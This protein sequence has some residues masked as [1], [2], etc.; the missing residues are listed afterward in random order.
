M[1]D[2][3]SANEQWFT[4]AGVYKIFNQSLRLLLAKR[5]KELNELKAAGKLHQFTA[6]DQTIKQKYQNSKDWSNQQKAIITSEDPLIIGA[7]CKVS[8]PSG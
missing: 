4:T 3:F 6:T 5:L 2:I 7:A 8:K 1:T